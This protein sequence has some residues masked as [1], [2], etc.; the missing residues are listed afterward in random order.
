MTL[1]T[2][3]ARLRVTGCEQHYTST[4]ED[5]LRP[6]QRVFIHETRSLA[7]SEARQRAAAMWDAFDRW[8]ERCHD[9]DRLGLS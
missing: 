1:P 5:M 6:G 8:L 9:Y 4:F 7:L 3:W 2:E